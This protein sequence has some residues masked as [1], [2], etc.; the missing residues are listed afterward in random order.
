MNELPELNEQ[1]AQ[2]GTKLRPY[3]VTYDEPFVQ[4]F[5]DKTGESLD[6]YRDESGTR[7]PPGIFLGA[8][9]RLLHE[10]YHYETGVHVSSDLSIVKAPMMGTSATV[11][12]EVVR[13]FEKNGDKYVVVQLAVTA[14]SG[15]V[16]ATVEHSSIYQLKSRRNDTT[17]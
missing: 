13:L 8:Y 7:V 16:L 15:E 4:G 12:G 1:S 10:T 14:D 17:A 2:P 3:A 11:S 5:L 6:A 9:A